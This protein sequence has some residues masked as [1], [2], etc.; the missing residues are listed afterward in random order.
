MHTF[1]IYNVY[2]L[3]ITDHTGRNNERHADPCYLFSTEYIVSEIGHI[4]NW[5]KKNEVILKL[6]LNSQKIIKKP[7]PF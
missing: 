5:N 4:E 6:H 7:H 2:I 1:Y 3:Y